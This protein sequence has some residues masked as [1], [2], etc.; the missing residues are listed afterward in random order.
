LIEDQRSG[1]AVSRAQVNHVHEA[2]GLG[3][4]AS[5]PK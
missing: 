4:R 5:F 1:I 3:T 2:H